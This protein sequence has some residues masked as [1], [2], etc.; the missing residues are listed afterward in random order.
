MILDCNRDTSYSFYILF[1]RWL[2]PI[3]SI[4]N[5]MQSLL[6]LNYDSHFVEMSFS[7]TAIHQTD[8]EYQRSSLLCE[9]KW[10]VLHYF[11]ADYDNSACSGTDPRV[12]SFDKLCPSKLLAFLY[13]RTYNNGSTPLFSIS[14]VKFVFGCKLFKKTTH[15][16][17]FSPSWG[18]I[19]FVSSTYLKKL[20]LYYGFR[21]TCCSKFSMNRSA[22]TGDNGD[23]MA[24][25]S[26]GS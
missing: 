13:T 3:T 25:P 19:A 10:T 16:S 5:L 18:Q 26:N 23:P 22:T 8:Y 1:F 17:N 20:G 15:S 12:L 4:F 11:L 21:S 24:T 7:N 6:N 2:L 14:I 9:L